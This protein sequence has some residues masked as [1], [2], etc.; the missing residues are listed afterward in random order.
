MLKNIRS[1]INILSVEQINNE[2]PNGWE[3]EATIETDKEAAEKAE[4]EKEAIITASKDEILK[5]TY[6]LTKI[7]WTYWKMLTLIL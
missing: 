1:T 7:T 6:L 3:L 5:K 4:A 2:L